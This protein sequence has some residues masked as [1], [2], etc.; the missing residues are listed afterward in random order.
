MT[1]IQASWDTVGPESTPQHQTQNETE[2]SGQQAQQQGGRA[3]QVLAKEQSW[4][5]SNHTNM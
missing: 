1:H 5:K 4:T 2:I 3:E